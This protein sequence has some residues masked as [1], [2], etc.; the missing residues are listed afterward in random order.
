[1]SVALETLY[2]ISPSAVDC[3]LGDGLALFDARCGA[4]FTLNRTGALIW[5]SARK[6]VRVC[7]LRSV[8]R[9]AC[10]GAPDDIDADLRSIVDA[11]VESGLFIRV[12]G[13]GAEA[14]TAHAA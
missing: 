9:A 4:S 7:D 2:Q 13:A 10:K 1:M 14:D 8:L 5:N 12:S 11:L 3:P 6:P